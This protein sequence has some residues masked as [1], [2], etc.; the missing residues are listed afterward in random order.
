AGFT[1]SVAPLGTAVPEPQL[2]L[3]WR[4]SDE[5]VIALDGDKAGLKAAYRVIDVALPLLEAGKGLRFAIMPEGKDPDDL[6]RAEGPEA[7]KTVL[8][9]AMPMVQLLWRQETE[10]LV[11][12]SPERKAALDKALRARIGKIQDP[13]LRHHYG[14][15]IK[16]LRFQAFRAQRPQQAP[17]QQQAYRG[18]GFKPFQPPAVPTAG[19][20]ASFLDSSGEDGER[21]LRL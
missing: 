14:E 9:A 8:D 2:Q 5:P 7:V 3:M 15:A 18:K 13:S 17:R 4:V 12:D 10:G 21:R 20:K 6:L 1:A 19:A 11:L 16:E